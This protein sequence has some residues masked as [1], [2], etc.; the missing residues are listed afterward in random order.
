MEVREKILDLVPYI[1]SIQ[2]V[3]WRGSRGCYPSVP[4]SPP[5]WVVHKG[6]PIAILIK[7]TPEEMD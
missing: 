4:D 1:E 3:P 2:T 6:C 5:T 7:G